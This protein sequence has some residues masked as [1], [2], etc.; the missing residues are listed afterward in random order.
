MI[1][2]GGAAP[3]GCMG[4][5]EEMTLAELPES[6]IGTD[7]T[8]R[9]RPRISVASCS[10]VGEP[11]MLAIGREQSKSFVDLGEHL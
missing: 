1:N 2:R 5:T 11:K 7:P 3:R 8:S 10:I 9:I 4:T 6:C